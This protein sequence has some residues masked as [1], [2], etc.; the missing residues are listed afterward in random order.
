M[1]A[2]LLIGAGRMGGALLRGW[3]EGRAGAITVVEPS[4]SPAL[5]ALA[6]NHGIALHTSVAAVTGK[7]FAACVVAM[8]PQVLKVEAAAL[9]PIAKAGALMISIAAGSNIA[10]MRKAWGRKARIVRAMPNTPGA[11]RKG[12]SALYAGREI[13]S[14]DRTLAEKLLTA[15]GETLWVPKESMI[16]AVTAVSGS[17][18]AYVFLMVEALADAGEAMGLPREASERLARAMVSGSGALLDADPRPPGDLRRDVTSKGGTTEAALKVLM[19]RN[20]LPKLMHRAVAAAT[21]RGK[22]LGK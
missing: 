12:I 3:I 15:L 9:A 10:L 19:A 11:I 21:K 1:A 16:D 8:K 5:R 4:P 13:S 2:L 18:P 20:G 14:K 6:R 17:G 7:R 22:E